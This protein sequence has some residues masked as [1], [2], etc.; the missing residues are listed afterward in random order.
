MKKLVPLVLIVI[1]TFIVTAQSQDM[2]KNR[3]PNQVYFED[4]THIFWTWYPNPFSPPTL[5]DTGKGLVY[6]DFT[7][8]CDFTDSVDVALV[9]KND[10]VVHHAY[11]KTARPPYFF[12]GLWVAGPMVTE[13]SL[14]ASYYKPNA[15][16]Y[17]RPVLIV[18]GR[19]KSL[20]ALGIPVKRGWHYWIDQTRPSKQ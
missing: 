7:F 20:R 5:K 13:Q 10:S 8:Y 16:E 6:G 18:G 14:P 9:T 1:F 4:S 3:Y 19:W 15:D 17:L 12:V 2:Q 11:L